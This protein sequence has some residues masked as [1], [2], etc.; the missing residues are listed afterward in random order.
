MS[1]TPAPASFSSLAWLEPQVLLCVLA[2][3]GGLKEE[4]PLSLKVHLC[5]HFG[6]LQTNLNQIIKT[7]TYDVGNVGVLIQTHTPAINNKWNDQS[8]DFPLLIFAK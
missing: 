1:S 5:C 7:W 6:Q 3:P 2:P 8:F 4:T